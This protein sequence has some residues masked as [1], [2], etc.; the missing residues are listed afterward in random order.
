M[1]LAEPP[2]DEFFDLAQ[3]TGKL[4]IKLR[5]RAADRYVVDLTNLGTENAS[6]VL[7]FVWGLPL[8]QQTRITIL[9]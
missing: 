5:N 4:E 1:R 9:R 3:F 2:K 6:R 7:M 8:E